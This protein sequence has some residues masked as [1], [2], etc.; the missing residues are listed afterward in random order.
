M[1][2][3]E[4]NHLTVTI[5]GVSLTLKSKESPEYL[6]QITHFFKNRIEE[7]QKHMVDTDPLKILIKAGLNITDELFKAHTLCSPPI[8]DE[9]NPNE[10]EEFTRRMINKI[11]QTLFDQ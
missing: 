6:Q 5:L 2:K 9:V 3:M 10:L 1:E 8:K 4:K 7:A 11:D